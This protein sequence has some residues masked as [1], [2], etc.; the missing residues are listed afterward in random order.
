MLPVETELHLHLKVSSCGG[1][2]NDLAAWGRR[3]GPAIS[4][5][6]IAGAV[7][8]SQQ[9]H[10]QRLRDGVGEVTC[11]RC[12]VTHSGADQLVRRGSRKRQLKTSSGVVTF[13][14]LQLTCRMCGRTW[15]PY[16]E[17][18]GLA[19][20]QRVSEELL[21]LLFEAVVDVSYGKSRRLANAWLG[22]A[23][24]DRTLH[25]AVQQRGS[26]VAFT[27]AARLNTVVADG[28]RV[29][30]GEK[31][32]GEEYCIAYQIHGRS[33]HRRRPVVKKRV[34]GF[35]I[36]I[37]GWDE[38][39]AMLGTQPK[40]VVTDGEH[41]LRGRVARHFPEARHQLCEWHVP[42]SLKYLMLMDGGLSLNRR[43]E[44]I[45][46]LQ[47][48]IERGD[49]RAYRRL[50]RRFHRGSYTRTYL[51]NA[52]PY[53]MYE[54]PSAVRTTSWAERQMRELN[55][56][57]DVGVKWSMAGVASLLKLKLAK[58]HNPDDYERIWTKPN[59]LDWNLVPRA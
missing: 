35:G 34:V 25:R 27:A 26:R 38:A 49:H 53:I 52:A 6:L 39:F 23:V 1:E 28:T 56:R 36:G 43:K 50:S 19:P 31:K 59:P 3:A 37:D 18:L 42:Y 32:T 12:G 33:R 29:R 17:L 21:Q 51:D 16:P 5:E 8:D 9:A 48:I 30:T 13:R 22:N 40:L 15:S 44:I 24:S 14:L 20:R 46:E 11:E 58:L 47:G 4:C 45:S 10:W 54:K 57:T 41:G 55:R 2:I 7:W